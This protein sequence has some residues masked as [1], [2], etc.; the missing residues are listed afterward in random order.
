ME[1]KQVK[2][3]GHVHLVE[4]LA[5]DN[6]KPEYSEKTVKDL[7]DLRKHTIEANKDLHMQEDPDKS[8]L[9][10][11]YSCKPHVDARRRQELEKLTEFSKLEKLFAGYNTKGSGVEEVDTFLDM[12]EHHKTSRST[13]RKKAVSKSKDADGEKILQEVDKL[14]ADIL[15]LYPSFKPEKKKIEERKTGADP[16]TEE[17]EHKGER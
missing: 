11:Y 15:A 7:T 6:A 3:L 17:G 8:A 4:I 5:N 12:M 2:W 14:R 13:R 1:E 10:K 9:L 16:P